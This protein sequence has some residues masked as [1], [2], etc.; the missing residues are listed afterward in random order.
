MGRRGW[1]IA[2]AAVLTAAAGVGAIA[3]VAAAQSSGFIR[4][5]AACLPAP[6]HVSPGVAHP[7]ET[8]VLSSGAATCDLGYPASREYVVVV[9]HRDVR[10]PPQ[11]VAVA[12]DGRFQAAVTVPPAFP[13]GDAVLSVTGSPYDQCDDGGGSGSCVGYSVVL[14]VD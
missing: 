2:L 14:V 13:R 1:S 3:F 6:L 7:G 10:T 5:A 12:T 8:V 11:R 4:P 9:Q